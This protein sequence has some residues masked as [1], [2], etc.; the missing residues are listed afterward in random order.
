MEVKVQATRRWRELDVQGPVMKMVV[1]LKEADDTD[2]V[3]ETCK[4]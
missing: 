3:K 2:T 4:N 1:Q